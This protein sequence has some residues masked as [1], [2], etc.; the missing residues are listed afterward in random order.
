[1]RSTCKCDETMLK[2]LKQETV[3]IIVCLAFLFLSCQAIFADQ[4]KKE[5][6]LAAAENWLALVDGEKYAASWQDAAAYFKRAVSE[7]Q[8]TQSMT[9][10][11][12][13]L[14]KVLSRTLASQSYTKTLPGAPDGEYMVIQYRTSFERK[15]A[16]IETVTPMLDPNGIWRVSGYYIK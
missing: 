13:P 15:A 3:V 14:G 10:F 16:S 2:K 9:A 7:D 12:R 11:R 5:A 1:M 4:T 8:W 6:A